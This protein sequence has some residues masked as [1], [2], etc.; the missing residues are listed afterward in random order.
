MAS[1]LEDLQKDAIASIAS[2]STLLRNAIA[3]AL[4]VAPE[5]YLTVAVPGTVI[6]LADYEKGGSFVYDVS[7]HSRTPT[8]VRQAEALLV[9]GMM[10]VATIMVSAAPK[11]DCKSFIHA[12]QIGNTGKSVVRSYSRSLDVLIPAKATISSADGI[13]SPGHAN[14]DH[15]L[16]F[17]TTT[18][19]GH[20]KT[21]VDV[22]RDKQ[23]AWSKE[24]SAWDAAMVKTAGELY[25]F[26]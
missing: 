16:E 8:T 23:I 2:V 24:R 12:P 9:D 14:Y 18:A 13:R 26:E 7:K 3:A 10:P 17:L 25:L 1:N 5:Q 4:P 20:S 21:V 11:N 6:D 15:A 22:Y 19:P